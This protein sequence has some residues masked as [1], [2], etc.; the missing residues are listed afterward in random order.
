VSGAT[1]TIRPHRPFTAL[2]DFVR[3]HLG[4]VLVVTVGVIL[5]IAMMVAYAPALWYDGDSGQYIMFSEQWPSMAYRWP[6]TW[7]L[8]AF[9][10]TGTFVTV[11]ALQHLAVV[12]LAVAGYVFLRRVGVGPWVGALAIAPLMFDANQITIEQYLLTETMFTVMVAAA[13]LLVVWRPQPSVWATGAAGV[14]VAI[15]WATR[16]TGL[17]VI[18]ALL[19]FM[20]VQWRGWRAPAAFVLGLVAFVAAIS[21]QAGSPKT[22]LS[23]ESGGYLYART[24]QFADCDRLQLRDELRP[25]CPT[26]PLGQR[27]ERP[28]WFLWDPQSPIVYARTRPELLDEFAREVIKQQPL[29]YAAKVTSDSAPFF[30]PTKPGPGQTCLALWWRPHYAPA[31]W[32]L[33]RGCVPHIA[34]NDYQ[35]DP[36]PSSSA[37]PTQLSR[38]M[39]AYGKYA[40][41][42]PLV[43]SLAILL[44]LAGA[45]WR[46]RADRRLRM[47]ALMY[48]AIGAGIMLLS[49]AT[50]MFDPRFGLP[51]LAFIPIAAAAGWHRIRTPKAA[52][53]P[54]SAPAGTSPDPHAD[55][56]AVPA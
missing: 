22:A 54:G 35:V 42:P 3:R 5:R 10:W 41:T 46:R 26:Q 24:A 47:I 52:P 38:V 2:T 7:F 56:A 55:A 21:W 33:D 1:P 4:A 36:Q 14:A 8:K 20:L 34:G 48:L 30:V 51:A 45:F 6:Y 18:A 40:V 39:R 9:E 32:S 29:D 16:A 44:A 12:L 37:A 17:V 31:N 53:R 49:V 13:A 11:V 23:L 27:P 28:D 15:G 43:T 25:L 50:A 19:L